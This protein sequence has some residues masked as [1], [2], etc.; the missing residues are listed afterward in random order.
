ME[1]IATVPKVV[2]IRSRGQLTIPQDIRETLQLDERT[3]INIFRVGR[4]LI[5]TPKR[6]ERA[7]LATEAEREMKREGIRLK[8]LIADLRVQ[9]KR[10]FEETYSKD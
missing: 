3:G 2:R 10:Y 8:D 5:L 6:L 7:S 4:V 1:N 9:R